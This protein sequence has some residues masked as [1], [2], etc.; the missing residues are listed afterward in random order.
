MGDTPFSRCLHETLF[1]LDLGTTLANTLETLA[2]PAM[3]SVPNLANLLRDNQ[4]YEH[5]L[6]RTDLIKKRKSSLLD[7]AEDPKRKQ[8]DGV[9]T[10][11]TVALLGKTG[12]RNAV[13]ALRLARILGTGLPKT[14]TDVITLDTPK[15]LRHAIEAEDFSVDNRI[16]HSEMSFAGGLLYDWLQ[17]LAPLNKQ[18]PKTA[19]PYL[20][21]IW[22]QSFK[23]AQLAYHIGSALKT[24]KYQ[25]YAFASGLALQ[26]G[27]YMMMAI[28]PAWPE[29]LE[30]MKEAKMDE[31]QPLFLLKERKTFGLTHSELSSLIISFFAPLKPMEKAVAFYQEPYLLRMAHPDLFRLSVVL[32]VSHRLATLGPEQR[33]AAKSP[34]DLLTRHQVRWLREL[35]ITEK[36]LLDALKVTKEGSK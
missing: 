5:L 18:L 19:G 11:R 14:E 15:L 27:R 23:T 29:F 35:A 3:S 31:L 13:I 21:E 30:E 1:Q 26:S 12:T 17:A 28:F 2:D 8:D 16:A 22:K 6:R 20:E 25:N 33:K 9:L 4:A 10:L 32:S 24:F 34:N 7:E 36:N